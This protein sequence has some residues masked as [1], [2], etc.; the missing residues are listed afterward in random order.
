MAAASSHT[1]SAIA[2]IDNAEARIDWIVAPIYNTDGNER[3]SPRHRRQQVGPSGGVGVRP[4]AQNLDL[5]R[6]YVKAVAPDVL[7]AA[8]DGPES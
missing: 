8:G 6:D 4:N 3:I 1:T 2:P 5:N 7:P